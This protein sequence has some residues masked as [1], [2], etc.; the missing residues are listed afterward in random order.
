VLT[1]AGLTN[2]LDNYAQI[3]EEK[4]PKTS[5]KKRKQVWPRYH[6]LGVVRKAL[7]HVRDNGAGK[8]YP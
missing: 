3:V 5:K 7:S 1:T 4:D 6:Q 8:R 2:I